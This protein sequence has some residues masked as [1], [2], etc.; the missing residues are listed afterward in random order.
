MKKEL[1]QFTKG[2]PLTIFDSDRSEDWTA[3]IIAVSIC[4]GVIF[5]L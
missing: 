3:I 2:T 5:F 4:F 1:S